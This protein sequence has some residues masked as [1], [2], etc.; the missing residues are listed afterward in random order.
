MCVYILFKVFKGCVCFIGLMDTHGRLIAGSHNRNEFVLIN[1]DE[2][3]KVSCAL[4]CYVHL[5]CICLF[6]HFVFLGLYLCSCLQYIVYFRTF[7]YLDMFK[8]INLEF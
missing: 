7:D 1:A 5:H 4:K 6:I 8:W 3:G 2:I